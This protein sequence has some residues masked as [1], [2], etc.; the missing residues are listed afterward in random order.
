MSE[1]WFHEISKY[2]K[3]F[4]PIRRVVRKNDVNILF[5][6]NALDKFQKINLIQALYWGNDKI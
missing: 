5:E 3:N 2:N 1:K 6:G 4:E